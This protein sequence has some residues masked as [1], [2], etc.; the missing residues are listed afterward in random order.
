ME[1]RP[2]ANYSLSNNYS[3]DEPYIS[4]YDRPKRPRGRP[5]IYTDEELKER[6]KE[7]YK[8]HYENNRDYYLLQKS[9][10]YELNKETQNARRRAYYQKHK[11]KIHLINNFF[12]ASAIVTTT[13]SACN[14]STEGQTSVS[15]DGTTVTVKSCT[16]NG[17]TLLSGTVT[18]E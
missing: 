3:L 7:T 9:I 2:P 10:S 16:A 17:E 12:S 5:K 1:S 14:T 6:R 15:D 4:V 11:G 18:I 8:K 13:L